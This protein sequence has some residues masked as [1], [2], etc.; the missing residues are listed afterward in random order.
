MGR[1]KTPGLFK[2]EGIWH[3]DK[4]IRGNRICESTGTSRLS[5]AE[6]F[7]ALRLEEVRQAQIYGVRLKRSFREAA[8]KYVAE[9]TISSLRNDIDQIKLLD[10]YIG[11]MSIDRINPSVLKPFINSRRKQGVRYRTINFGLKTVRR[12]LNLAAT[13]WYDENGHTWLMVAP[14][15]KLLPETDSRKPYPLSWDEQERLFLELPEHLRDMALFKVNTGCREQEV[16]S[17]RWEWE[18][19]VPEIGTSVFIIPGENVKNREDRVVIL[20]DIAREI[21]DGRRDI[22]PEFVF[23]FQGRRITRMNNSSWRKARKRAK[24]SQ[25]R[26]HDLKHTFARRLRSAGVG[27]EDRQDLLGHTSKSVTTHYS[28][29]ELVNLIQAVNRIKTQKSRKSPALVL[30]KRKVS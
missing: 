5:E 21:V 13:E 19:E 1:K 7:L 6:R 26:V 20:G 3:I 28:G 27:F 8:L 29:A 12:I 11:S 18:V 23:S 30:L 24:L 14:K 10:P 15:I 17:L 25:V 4:R 9:A 2:R 16:C 22:H